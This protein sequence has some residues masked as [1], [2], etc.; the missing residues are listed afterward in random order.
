MLL[1]FHFFSVPSLLFVI[2]LI[3][4]GHR[5]MI[6]FLPTVAV[7]AAAA[8]AGFHFILCSC[9]CCVV[10]VYVVFF[11]TRTRNKDSNKDPL[12]S[13]QAKFLHCC[14]VSLLPLLLLLVCFHFYFS[15]YFLM[16]PR[17]LA[18][19]IHNLLYPVL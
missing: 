6:S 3:S 9:C 10:V 19:S 16:P 1:R 17:R 5:K 7:S 18:F 15:Y 12:A 14:R 8:L 2:S 4:F 11:K 13:F